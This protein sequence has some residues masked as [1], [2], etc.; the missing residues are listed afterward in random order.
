MAFI[1]LKVNVV[2][3]THEST[4]RS[5]RSAFQRKNPFCVKRAFGMR[6]GFFCW[7]GDASLFSSALQVKFSHKQCLEG[8]RMTHLRKG[9]AKWFPLQNTSVGVAQCVRQFSGDAKWLIVRA[10]PVYFREGNPDNVHTSCNMT[11]WNFNSPRYVNSRVEV[12]YSKFHSAT[13]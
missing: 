8:F 5:S 2:F 4:G 10:G 12:R 11:V 1:V 13:L 7:E 9:D 6:T 3:L